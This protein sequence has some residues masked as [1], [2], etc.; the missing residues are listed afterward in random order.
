MIEDD[1]TEVSLDGDFVRVLHASVA[2]PARRPRDRLLHVSATSTVY[3]RVAKVPETPVGLLVSC[4]D[5][6]SSSARGW[7]NIS[8][9]DITSR[10]ASLRRQYL[11]HRRC[12]NSNLISGIHEGGEK[13]GGRVGTLDSACFWVERAAPEGSGVLP[14]TAEA[15]TVPA[16]AFG[17]TSPPQ[18]KPY[19]SADVLWREER[20]GASFVAFADGRAR[21]VFSDR[22]IVTLGAPFPKA[23]CGMIS[24]RAPVCGAAIGVGR[25]HSGP[26]EG[27]EKHG[28][29]D[30]NV[31]C[32]LPDGT[33]RRF[34]LLSMSREEAFSNRQGGAISGN[35]GLVPCVAAVRR[36]EVRAR[37]NP[38]ERR[39]S[40]A[41]E[42]AV[43]L[44]AS[45][46]LDQNRRFIALHQ[47]MRRQARPDCRG[48][49]SAVAAKTRVSSLQRSEGGSWASTPYQHRRREEEKDQEY[50]DRRRTE[51]VVVRGRAPTGDL[52][53]NA[54]VERVLEAN[55]K[56]LLGQ[57]RSYS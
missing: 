13:R 30:R 48:T 9:G 23:A 24:H 14:P 57:T 4:N 1:G 22:T 32:V 36:F 10:A 44:A 7:R 29:V 52:E 54:L 12:S 41:R 55:L 56:V 8:L 2:S 11:V 51:G 31:E 19:L 18:H 40:A 26:G 34:S 5:G 25:F 20:G 27:E 16:S 21:G 46:E 35:R 45:V 33:V 53:R 38:A 43:R 28:E 15:A 47:L 42:E 3:F 17:V 50:L 39:A 37:A 49:Q 6:D